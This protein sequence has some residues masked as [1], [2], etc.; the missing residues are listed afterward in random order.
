MKPSGFCVPALTGDLPRS[1]STVI[2]P[3]VTLRPASCVDSTTNAG[4][5]R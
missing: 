3:R 2:G 1:A 4:G 5:D